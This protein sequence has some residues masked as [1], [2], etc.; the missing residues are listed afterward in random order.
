MKKTTQVLYD[1]K[2]KNDKKIKKNKKIP[3]GPKKE[4]DYYRPM[5]I[6]NAFNDS[7]I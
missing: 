7:Y 6:H 5:K 2:I 4:E 3:Y 1:S